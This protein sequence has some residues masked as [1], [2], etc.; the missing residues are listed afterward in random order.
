[1]SAR[2]PK[3]G[4]RRRPGAVSFEAARDV[5]D[6]PRHIDA[7]VYAGRLQ[8]AVIESPLAHPT[9]AGRRRHARYLDACI[10]DALRRG[11]TPYASH[12]M[13]TGALDDLMPDERE[14]GIAAGFRMA[15]VLW[16][17]SGAARVF[18]MDE[19]MSGGMNRGLKHAIMIGQ[20]IER[21][22]VPGW[23]RKVQARKRRR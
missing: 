7:D 11:E 23:K 14:A 1:V 13:L 9:A 19:G 16:F 4:A 3:G 20:R 21:R 2:S 5:W 8:A 10:A 6:E 18:Y 17:G 15:E 22:T 12:R